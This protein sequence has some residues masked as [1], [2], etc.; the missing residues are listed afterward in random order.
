VELKLISTNGERVKKFICYVILALASIFY[1]FPIY[2]LILTSFKLP[3]DV[4]ANPPIWVTSRLTID[5]YRLLFG[6]EIKGLWGIP[7]YVGRLYLPNITPNLINSIIVGLLSTIIAVLLGSFLA[8]GVA[9]FKFGGKNLTTWLL[10]L[11][12]VPPIVIVIPLFMVFRTINLIDTWWALIIAYL[13]VNIPF[14]TVVLIGFF[15]D[16]PGDIYDAAL[17]DGYTKV[18]VFFKI[19]LPLVK[20]G[21]MA[22]S[23]ISFLTCWNE[24]LIAAVLTNSARAQTLPVYTTQFAQVERAT[25]WGSAAAAGVISMIP[26]IMFSI[27]IQKYLVRGLTMGMVRG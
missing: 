1:I 13:L 4:V 6:Q 3:G 12:M 19:I 7:E 27:S 8:Y 25:A 2:W 23:I 15:N 10:S 9:K 22:V 16:V 24:M 11:R 21:L 17:I 20:P 18:G 14:I 5:N 26:L